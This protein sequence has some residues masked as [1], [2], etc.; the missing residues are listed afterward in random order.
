LRAVDAWRS[1]KASRQ[2]P[3]PLLH[4]KEIALEEWINAA[5]E[6]GIICEAP[7]VANWSQIL[8]VMKPNGKDYRFC[9]DY[10]L[11]NSFMESAGWPIPHIGSILRR[12]ASNGPRLFATMD[13][14]QCFLSG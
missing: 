2:Q 13:A 11:L 4:D 8:M 5:L 10:T 6:A 12:I 3:R 1:S 14:T 9:V 7:A